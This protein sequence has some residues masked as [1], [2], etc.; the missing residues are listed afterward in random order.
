MYHGRIQVTDPTAEQLIQKAKDLKPLLLEQGRNADALRQLPQETMSA[1]LDARFFSIAAP[2]RYHGLELDLDVL[3][4]VARELGRGC[5]ST[6]WVMSLLGTHNWMAGQ[7][8]QLAQEEMFGDRGYLLAPAVFAPSGS[9]T[10]VDGGYQISGRWRFASGSMHSS[11][12]MVSALVEDD[13]DNLV[14]MRVAAL[15]RKD[16][17]IEDTWHTSGMRGTG[18]N[19]IVINKAFVPEYRSIPFEELLEGRAPGTQLSD[20]PIY[21]IP[22]VP[23]LSYTAAAPALGIGLGALDTF[24]DYLRERIS[25]VGEKQLDKPAAQIRLAEADVELKAAGALLDSGVKRLLDCARS[26]ASFS[27]DERAA[28]RAEA[29]YIATMVKRAVDSLCEA[30]GAR[31]QFEDHPLQRFQ[32]DINTLRGHVVFDLDS[33]MEMHGRVLLGLEPNQPL[34]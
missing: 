32:R 21:R 6:A 27:V 33:T 11:W 22:L 15:P 16:V 7:F 1:L 29:C 34:V 31:A 10:P 17:V 23:Y 12:F 3:L 20:N 18:S 28:Y 24:R 8:P 13:K 5:A 2:Q 19:D 25:M 9:A 30:S 4:A 14:G 26:G